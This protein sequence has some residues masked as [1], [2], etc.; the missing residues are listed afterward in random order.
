MASCRTS[1]RSSLRRLCYP[2]N[3]GNAVLGQ[4]DKEPGADR[5]RPVDRAVD[6]EQLADRAGDRVFHVGAQIGGLGQRRFERRIVG[7][8]FAESQRF[9]P[10]RHFGLSVDSA[11]MAQALFQRADLDS[12][13]IAVHVG[14]GRC[15]NI[16]VADEVGH[17]QARRLLVQLARRTGLRHHGIGHDDDAVRHGQRFLLVVGDVGDGQVEL[18][19]QVPNILAHAAAQLGVQV[20]QRLVEQQ[21]LRLQHQGAGD[22]HALLLA[23]RELRGQ[24]VVVALEADQCHLLARHLLRF[25]LRGA[26]DAGAVGD[27]LQNGHVREQG[28]GLEHHRHVAVGGRKLGHVAAADQDLA[29][30]RHLQPRDHAQGR[31]LAAARGAE[32]RHQRARLDR[33]RHVVD[34]RDR[35]VALGHV[36]KLDRCGRFGHAKSP[37]PAGI[38]WAVGAYLGRLPTSFSQRAMMRLRST[39]EPYFWKS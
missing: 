27:V 10:Y 28:V 13:R 14:H 7:P 19:L 26:A 36:A 39:P 31:G 25:G 9:R 12:R 33:E 30:G 8:R 23:T 38:P 2:G 34:R 21:H 16:R 5:Q 18:A 37:V 4:G 29:L 22:R 3:D 35:A 15:N 11:A 1:I 20:R 6:H 17:E 32:Q 24:A